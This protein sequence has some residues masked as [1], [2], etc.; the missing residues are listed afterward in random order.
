MTLDQI[1]RLLEVHSV[2]AEVHHAADSS[3]DEF[4]RVASEYLDKKDH[5]VIVNYQKWS[6][7]LRPAA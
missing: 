5:Y 2:K 1:G 7:I 3:L 6:R 4:R